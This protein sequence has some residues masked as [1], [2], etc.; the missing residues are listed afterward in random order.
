[1]SNACAQS[2]QS[3][4]L[5]AFDTIFSK[6]KNRGDS[7]DCYGAVSFFFQDYINLWFSLWHSPKRLGN[8]SG[9]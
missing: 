9:H 8:S 6:A 3:F 5:S 1:M 4:L 2:D 7:R